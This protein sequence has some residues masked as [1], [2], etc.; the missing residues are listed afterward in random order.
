MPLLAGVSRLSPGWLPPIAGQY[1]G[2]A[3][4]GLG[5]LLSWVAA[6]A[7]LVMSRGRALPLSRQGGWLALGLI[8]LFVFA[9]SDRL[10]VGHWIIDVSYPGWMGALTSHL[11]SVGRMAWPLLYGFI[12]LALVVLARWCQPRVAVALLGALVLI[13]WWDVS[14]WQTYVQRNME[15]L[16]PGRDVERPF[17]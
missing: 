9:L 11:R 17:A 7:V 13:Q 3:Y 2:F 1:E 10:V 12:F 8:V 4:A 5:I 15:H 16:A 14:L 6:V